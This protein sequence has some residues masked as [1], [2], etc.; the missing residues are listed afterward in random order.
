MTGSGTSTVAPVHASDPA[1]A[2]EPP[3]KERSLGWLLLAGGLIGFAAAFT[4]M[5]EKIALLKDPGYSPSCSLNPVLNCGSIM[6]TDQAEVF[7]FPN[8]LIG[9]AAFP[10]LAATGAALLAGARFARWYWIGLQTGVTLAAG[11]VGWLI[12]QSLYRIGAL[13]PYCMVVWALVLPIFVFVT[14]RNAEVG[15]LGSR[16]ALSRTVRAIAAW[17]LTIVTAAVLVVV[18]LIAEQ[19]WYYWRTLV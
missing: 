5:V 16:L 7:G 3:S 13:C 18:A 8:P 10:V 2:P 9:V 14:A 1:P 17:R 15:V 19:F 11:F 4:L 12:F 6:K